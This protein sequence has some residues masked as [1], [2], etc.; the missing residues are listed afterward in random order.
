MFLAH[1]PTGSYGLPI[2]MEV[3]NCRAVRVN[4]IVLE[5]RLEHYQV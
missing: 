3:T 5:N 1:N 2:R 4:L